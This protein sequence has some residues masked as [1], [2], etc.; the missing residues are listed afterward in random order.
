MKPLIIAAA[1][2]LA[3]T[4]QAQVAPASKPV[5]KAGDVAV[6]TV[7]LVADRQTTEDSVTVT[8]VENGLIKAR[9]ARANRSPAETEAIYT[10]EWGSIL[11]GSNGSRIDP[12]SQVLKFPLKVGD[13]WDQQYGVLVSNGARSRVDLGAKVVAHEKVS[14]PAGDFDAFKVETSGWVNGVSWT[15]SFKVVSTAWYAPAVNR[16]VRTEYK[17]YR[18]DG[19]E[20][21]SELKSFTAAK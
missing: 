21:I 2:L 9:Y 6:Y 11:V 18:R 8:G 5:V 1:A 14:T 4:V 12:P 20:S 19:L 13:T 15:G 3:L 7:K 17:E 10:D 16:I